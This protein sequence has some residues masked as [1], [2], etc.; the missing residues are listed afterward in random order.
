VAPLLE[1]FHSPKQESSSSTNTTKN[2]VPTKIKTTTTLT[3]TTSTN[4]SV[5]P[6]S[7]FDDKVNGGG[8]DL[9]TF[10]T[11]VFGSSDS[12]IGNFRPILVKNGR[13]CHIL[14][15]TILERNGILVIPK[16]II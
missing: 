10:F 4:S 7:T 8:D 2:S 9:H 6:S 12:E 5:L 14:K 15:C 16:V 11:T 13:N 3:A 1:P